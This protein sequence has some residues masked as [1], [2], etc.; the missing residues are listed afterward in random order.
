MK[1]VP[2]FRATCS[3]SYAHTGPIFA[4]QWAA[5]CFGGNGFCIGVGADVQ[6]QEEK[7]RRRSGETD[8][9]GT[10]AGGSRKSTGRSSSISETNDRAKQ[11]ERKARA[12]LYWE[13][14]QIRDPSMRGYAQG[15]VRGASRGEQGQSC[16]VCFRPGK[17]LR[18]SIA[19][20]AGA[21]WTRLLQDVFA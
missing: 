12:Q 17:R 16:E 20:H 10:E 3:Y 7:L 18:S 11:M 9:A 5:F 6:D 19:G 1:R 2:L 8:R 13:D 21:W 4:V 14:L 15:C